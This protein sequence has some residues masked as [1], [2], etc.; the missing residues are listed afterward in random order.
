MSAWQAAA[1]ALAIGLLIGSER[2]RSGPAQEKVGGLAVNSGL[3]TF[4]LAALAGALAALIHPLA[5]AGL[6]AAAAIVVAAGHLHP[7]AAASGT[8]TEIALVL[9]VVLGGLTVTY[10]A[11]AAAA[12]VAT[13]VL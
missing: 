4:A 3:R 8:T 6:I 13:A 12:G 10:P 11:L 5:L 9:T 7:G 2:E 1:I